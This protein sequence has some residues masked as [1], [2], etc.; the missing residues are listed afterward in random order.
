MKLFL[1][2]VSCLLFFQSLN[3]ISASEDQDF[4]SEKQWKEHIKNFDY[5]EDYKTIKSN[6]RRE[7]TNSK[8]DFRG[9]RNIFIVIVIVVLIILIIYIALSLYKDL[10][11]RIKQTEIENIA[12]INNIEEADLEGMLQEA[13]GLGK[14]DEVIRYKYLIL[15]RSLNKQKLIVWK[16][17]KTNG[18]YLKEMYNKQGFELFRNITLSFEHIWYGSSAASEADYLHLLPKFDHLNQIILKIEPKQ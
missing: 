8:I 2:I 4:I 10:R 14:F 13:L 11:W 9:A 6:D 15:I 5:T 12:Q 7:Q 1:K 17:D 3:S 18:Q 16:K